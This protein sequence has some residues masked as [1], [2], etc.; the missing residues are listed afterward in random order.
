VLPETLA[1]GLKAIAFSLDG[2]VEATES[3]EHRWVVGVQWHPELPEAGHPGFAEG[4]RP[5]FAAFVEEARRV[6]EP[7]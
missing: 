2:L 1:P 4:M 3:R 5:L 6:R 7:A